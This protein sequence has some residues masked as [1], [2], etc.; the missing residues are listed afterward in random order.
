MNLSLP[1]L[2]THPTLIHPTYWELYHV[3]IWITKRRSLSLNWQW[4]SPLY[5]E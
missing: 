3:R 2:P 4:R 5:F 1:T